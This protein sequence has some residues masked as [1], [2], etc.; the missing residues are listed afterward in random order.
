MGELLYIV[1]YM[2]REYNDSTEMFESLKEAKKSFNNAFLYK[3]IKSVKLA[4]LMDWR[5]KE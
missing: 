3:S 5:V 1:I 2:N 4:R